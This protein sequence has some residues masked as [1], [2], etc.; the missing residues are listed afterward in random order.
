MELR[1]VICF[2]DN[3]QL[4]MV[5]PTLS[6]VNTWL[7]HCEPRVAEYKLVTA[8][9]RQ[10]EVHI[11]S[12]AAHLDLKVDVKFQVALFVGCPIDVE[13]WSWN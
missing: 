6:S 5:Y 8:Q 3:G 1:G 11:I 12:D 2:K 4:S 13:K 10:E 7:R 9:I